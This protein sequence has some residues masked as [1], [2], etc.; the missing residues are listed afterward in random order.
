RTSK[1]GARDETAV[2]APIARLRQEIA[3]PW[4]ERNLAFAIGEQR[5]VPVAVAVEGDGQAVLAPIDLEHGGFGAEQRLAPP[6]ELVPSTQA[7]CRGEGQGE[8]RVV[9]AYDAA[10]ALADQGTPG[11][12]ASGVGGVAVVRWSAARAC[13]DAIEMAV[14][15][16]RYEQDPGLY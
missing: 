13:L 7:R 4:G 2:G 15:D 1:A 9:L 8:A 11:I 5:G 14:R 6:S 12:A 16:E 3:A 10:I